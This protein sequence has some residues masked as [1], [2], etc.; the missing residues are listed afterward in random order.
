MLC[1][2]VTVGRDAF[3]GVD[4]IK[5]VNVP[6]HILGNINVDKVVS[7]EINSGDKI[8]SEL[9]STMPCLKT[10]ILNVDEI[11]D[12]AFVG[13]EITSAA[14]S[15]RVIGKG[16]FDGVA[17]LVDL[18]VD[19]DLEFVGTDAFLGTSVVYTEIDGIAYLG[20]LDGPDFRPTVLISVVESTSE[21]FQK[22]F[23][24]PETLKV[25]FYDAFID[26]FEL[27]SVTLGASVAMLGNRAFSYCKQLEK[28]AFAKDGSL[29]YIG[30]SA[31]KEC[32]ALTAVTLPDGLLW[33][34]N[35]AFHGCTYITSVYLPASLV[36]EDGAVN[37]GKAVFA[38]CA[39]LTEIYFDGT[40]EE[41][42]AICDLGLSYPSKD[43]KVYFYSELAPETEG[44]F[45]HFDEDGEIVKY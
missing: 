12:R 30:E 8:T 7:L 24:A 29:I 33:L 10:V 6:L 26:C 14:L 5:N 35:G 44:D 22:D 3:S 41:W 37:I 16:A 23:V 27:E 31:F 4:N 34:G 20:Y 43:L 1:N 19:T 32:D 18:T 15:V 45:W 38:A 40:A 39:N 9:V 2:T 11:C 13:S 21:D 25:I 17:T 28:L 42:S 36:D